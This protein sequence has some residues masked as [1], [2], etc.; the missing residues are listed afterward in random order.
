M[1]KKTLMA[2]VLFIVLFT[3]FAGGVNR[4]P[5]NS[6]IETSFPFH[7]ECGFFNITVFETWDMLNTT[8]EDKP[9]LIDVRRI[10]EY[11]TER[12]K[13]PYPEDWPRWFPYQYRYNILG[14]AIMNQG[15]LLQA[16]MRYYDG[17]EI[18]LYC[19]TANRT[20]FSAEILVENGF[21]GIVY[22]MV[23][24]IVEWKHVGL[25]TVQGF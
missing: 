21:N 7:E 19:R 6:D 12:I 23:G 11:F 18:I 9:V 17:K 24:G 25:P 8:S 13:T 3:S 4:I 20:F 15:V 1:I 10:D 2:I 16:F 22:N 5:N 14:G